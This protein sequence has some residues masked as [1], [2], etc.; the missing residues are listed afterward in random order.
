[1]HQGIKHDPTCHL[2]YGYK[3]P[4]GEI[5][6]VLVSRR[7]PRLTRKGPRLPRREPRAATPARADWIPGEYDGPIDH[8]RRREEARYLATGGG[9][10][11]P[12]FRRNPG[13]CLV[14]L[15]K[16]QALNIPVG[17]A[18]EN[19][20]WNEAIGKGA[21]TA[22]LMAGL[23]K[24]AGYRFKVTTETNQRVEMTFWNP[25]GKRLGTS[26]W[27]MADAIA[28]GIAGHHLWQAFPED[29]LWARCLMRGARRFAQDIGTGL[30]YT[31]RE[32]AEMSAE[33][34]PVAEPV[35]AEVQEYLD[36]AATTGT[37]AENIKADILVRARRAKLLSEPAGAGRT[38]GEALAEMYG[39]ARA[40]EADQ[41]DRLPAVE[42]D[43]DERPAGTGELE[44]GCNA[45][46]F[47]ETG[48][49]ESRCR[50]A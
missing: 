35:T 3:A 45:A 18:V 14:L 6:S 40:R 49:H 38:L 4:K 37:T 12:M 42:P 46:M 41:V 17:I 1:V 28:A 21:M 19:L 2:H 11:A 24:R 8:A 22:Q 27:T 32:L 36:E 9:T 16:A 48:D 26:R 31:G 7:T 13:A 47:V 44:C 34:E 20:H 43:T 23:L 5:V 39:A 30:A 50:R 10:I 33:A 29:S 15:Y 25:Q